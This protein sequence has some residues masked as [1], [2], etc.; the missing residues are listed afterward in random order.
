MAGRIG[1]LAIRPSNHQIILGGAQGGIWLFDPATGTWSP[2]RRTPAVARH[3]RARDRPVERRDRVRGHRRGRLS[4]DSY[5]GNGI[6]KSTDGGLTGPRS[7]ATTRGV[8]TSASSWIRPTRT[9]STRRPARPRR[10]PPRRPPG[11]RGS[12]SGS[13]RTAAS[14]GTHPQ[15]RGRARRHGPR[16]GPAEPKMLFAA[17]LGDKI[18]RRTDGGPRGQPTMT[19]LPAGRLRAGAARASPS[20]SRTR[21][22]GRGAVRGLRLDGH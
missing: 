3:R 20:A 5:F 9:T 2:R 6:L 22:P 16:D 21:G 10:R 4:G 13:P 8:S 1:A 17:F 19:G 14:P 15:S 18:Y 11:T 12:A 7:P